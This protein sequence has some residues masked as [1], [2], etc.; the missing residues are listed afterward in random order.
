MNAFVATSGQL[1][2]FSY[3]LLWF[4]SPN[5]F[6][7]FHRV[8]SSVHLCYGKSFIL[9]ISHLIADSRHKKKCYRRNCCINMNTSHKQILQ[10]SNKL[11]YFKLTP[12]NRVLLYKLRA[13]HTVNK[14]P[15]PFPAA[16]KFIKMFR[17]ARKL[18]LS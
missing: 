11:W 17:T 15:P 8:I 9:Q 2:T 4:T 1:E 3:L 14:S 10:D 13:A 5:L 12:E 18:S 7:H 16:R 6:L